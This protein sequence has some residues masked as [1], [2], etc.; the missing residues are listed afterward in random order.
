MLEI[1]LK[2]N[3]VSAVSSAL[4]IRE[5][6]PV[7]ALGYDEGRLIGEQ[8]C[9]L[10]SGECSVAGGCSSCELTKGWHC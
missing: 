7:I 10:V 4:G 2:D 6:S 9:D 3:D 5:A 8:M 1:Q